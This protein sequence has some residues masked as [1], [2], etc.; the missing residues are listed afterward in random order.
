MRHNEPSAGTDLHGYSSTVRAYKTRYQR[1]RER[2]E[3]YTNWL[4]RISCEQYALAFD[5][6]YR[7]GH[8]TTNLVEC[9]TS[10]LKGA[11]NLLVTTLVKAMFYRLDELFTR[12]RAEV[13]ACINAGHVFSELVTS[14]LHANQW[15]AGNIQVSCFDRHN[16]VFEVRE[17]MHWTY[18]D[19]GVTVVNSR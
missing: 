15:A 12:K 11:C 4:D 16:G 13:E 3:A 1:L 14:K 17:S 7:W 10:V 8:M 5:G 19:N 18:N 2:G 9:K 6:G